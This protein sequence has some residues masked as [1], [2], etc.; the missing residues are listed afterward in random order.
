MNKT[1]KVRDSP[2]VDGKSQTDVVIPTLDV[3]VEKGDKGDEQ[4]EE[5]ID[6]AVADPKKGGHSRG[7]KESENP[8]ADG[9]VRARYTG[10]LMLF[11]ALAEN[12]PLLIG[13]VLAY[14]FSGL[15]GENRVDEFIIKVRHEADMIIESKIDS[16]VD[17]LIGKMKEIYEHAHA[18][19]KS[20][21]IVDE[22]V[23]DESF[24]EQ[25][26]FLSFWTESVAMPYHY[27]MVSVTFECNGHVL[28]TGYTDESGTSA[29][30]AYY[31]DMTAARTGNVVCAPYNKDSTATLEK[32]Y[33]TEFTDEDG[34]TRIEADNFTAHGSVTL[35]DG[36]SEK[37]YQDAIVSPLKCAWSKVF[38]GL[39]PPHRL[40][41]MIAN[42]IEKEGKVQGTVKATIAVD[43][44]VKVIQEITASVPGMSLIILEGQELK[45][46]AAT[47]GG[48]THPVVESCTGEKVVELYTLEEYAEVVKVEANNRYGYLLQYLDDNP[49]FSKSI[50]DLTADI[51]VENVNHYYATHG[52][53]TKTNGDIELLAGIHL[54]DQCD[55]DYTIYLIL[56][57]KTM[58]EEIVQQNEIATARI[59]A[60]T[61]NIWIAIALSCT[62]CSLCGMVLTKAIS[63]PLSVIRKDINR[64]AELD[65]TG[66]IGRL[67]PFVSE[68]KTMIDEYIKLKV[69]LCDFNCFVP[70]H[71]LDELVDL[72]DD[73]LQRT[74]VSKDI[75]V[76][77]VYVSNLSAAS[78]NSSADV[79][80]DFCNSFIGA[81]IDHV[82]NMN[83]TTVDF[84]GDSLFAIFNAPYDDPDYIKNTIECADEI[85]ALG[86]RVKG[87]LMAVNP[88]FSLIEI[89]IGLHCGPALVGK[90]GSQSRLKY[91]AVG[92]TVN[93]GS[94]I[95]NMN[96]RYNSK[97]TCSS[98]FLEALNDHAENYCT[99]PMEYVKVQGR[100]EPVLLHEIAGLINSV[101]SSTR[102]EF[103][104]H[105]DLF[106]AVVE[107]RAG[108][109]EVD[110]HIQK[111]G[112]NAEFIKSAAYD[113]NQLKELKK[114]E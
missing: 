68:I 73:A 39:D 104:E 44:I 32:V 25:I 45:V 35:Y 42:T 91:C 46:I 92:D 57:E 83:G 106:Y 113:T 56:D 93:L 81:S 20:G 38:V 94:R 70:P 103:S 6:Q 108:M 2:P 22:L 59:A 71:I 49:E 17:S 16:M 101:E 80:A 28:G 98:D 12:V 41:K 86:A 64:V 82:T 29:Y 14:I 48:N 111:Y 77:F 53:F 110:A 54:K 112:A 90:I 34:W 74:A 4:Q 62:V 75:S 21:A 52:T 5:G 55:L 89:R 109:D 105:S 23:A 24:W 27:P 43:E 1:N 79:V 78:H 13:I 30:V 67:R 72:G 47:E 61:R 100:S 76:L 60:T 95:E 97:M 18:T 50:K 3:D 85:L 69:T 65:F 8:G 99:R 15:Y 114:Q 87:E 37:I 19:T 31:T 33:R 96:R 63:K 26:K 9:P 36:R 51:S 40:S 102:Q 66:F 7:S 10:P 107:K 88:D 58:I 84:F 11:L